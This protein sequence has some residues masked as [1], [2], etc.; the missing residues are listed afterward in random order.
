M[1]RQGSMV[2]KPC[3]LVDAGGDG[4]AGDAGGGDLV[5]DAPSHI[6]LP[7]LSPVAPPGV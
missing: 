2:G 5:I 6:F 1:N 3:F 7:G 4:F